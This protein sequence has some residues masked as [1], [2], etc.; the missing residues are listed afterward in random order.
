MNLS[1]SLFRVG[2][3]DGPVALTATLLAFGATSNARAKSIAAGLG[4]AVLSLL[5]S[6]MDGP[7]RELS[8]K[9][10]QAMLEGV[11][12]LVQ[13]DGGPGLLTG[14]SSEQQQALAAHGRYAGKVLP[15]LLLLL[16]KEHL[17]T[18]TMWGDGR[19]GG[20]RVEV[21]QLVAVLVDILMVPLVTFTGMY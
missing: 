12:Q 3:F 14:L 6:N 17:E 10:V 5:S 18:L 7:L 19:Q 9:G 1:F 16:S 8:P 4:D 21:A 13:A 2:L 20:G 15:E 11:Q